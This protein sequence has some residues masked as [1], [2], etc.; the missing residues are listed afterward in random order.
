MSAIATTIALTLGTAAISTAQPPTRK[1]QGPG[2]RP[3]RNP[4]QQRGQGSRIAELI[5]QGDTRE[6]LLALDSSLQTS[7]RYTGSYFSQR[8]FTLGIRRRVLQSRIDTASMEN[9]RRS[10]MHVTIKDMRRQLETLNNEIREIEKITRQRQ[11]YTELNGIMFSLSRLSVLRSTPGYPAEE[12]EREKRNVGIVKSDEEMIERYL[13]TYG[14]EPVV[15]GWSRYDLNRIQANLP[16]TTALVGWVELVGS[17]DSS[18]LS[19]QHWACI[20]RR[21]EMP[22]WIRIPGEEGAKGLTREIFAES[23]I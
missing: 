9:H 22:L 6:A 15:L 23:M 2:D 21:N 8:Y 3:Y 16:V 10:D 1:D 7:A 18:G 14:P 4:L 5:L 12:L 11:S 17:D 19:D 13:N 20:L